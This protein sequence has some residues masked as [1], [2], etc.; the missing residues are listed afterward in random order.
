MKKMLKRRNFGKKDK[1]TYFPTAVHAPKD[2]SCLKSN[3]FFRAP[4]NE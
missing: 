3:D 1:Y 2:S 4:L